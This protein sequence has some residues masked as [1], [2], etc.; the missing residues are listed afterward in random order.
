MKINPDQIESVRQQQ[1][2]KKSQKVA[3]NG[4]AF[5]EL[6][7]QEVAKASASGSTAAAQAPAPPMAVNP[8]LHMQQVEN[9]AAVGKEQQVIAQQVDGALSKLENFAKNLEE[10]S[11]LKQAHSALEELSGD[12]AAMKN[13]WPDLA[14]KHPELGAVVNELEVLSVTERFKFNRGDY[15]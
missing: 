1:E 4:N 13:E 8:L 9:T 7:S 14:E 15:Q 11:S 3:G 2:Q 5:G 12:L 6:L 10:P